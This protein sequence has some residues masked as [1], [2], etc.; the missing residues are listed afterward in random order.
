MVSCR[1]DL[2]EIFWAYVEKRNKKG[3]ARSKNLSLLLLLFHKFKRNLYVSIP[4]LAPDRDV[5]RR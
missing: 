5:Y 2:D 3:G 4:V 1:V